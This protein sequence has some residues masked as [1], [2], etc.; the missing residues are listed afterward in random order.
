MENKRTW[1]ALLPASPQHC[2]LPHL[3]SAASSHPF[4]PYYYI[5]VRIL[6]WTCL[7]TAAYVSC[8]ACM[9]ICVSAHSMHAMCADTTPLMRHLR[10][11]MLTYADVCWRMVTY[12][13]LWSGDAGPGVPG[14]LLW[15]RYG[16]LRHLHLPRT[17]AYRCSKEGLCVC[18]CFIKAWST[19]S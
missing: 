8:Y 9:C 3:S 7:H 19:A 18:V 12:G 4:L 13:W 10:S 16:Q 11:R 1:A 15:R 2:F 5:R 17:H 6:V 14:C